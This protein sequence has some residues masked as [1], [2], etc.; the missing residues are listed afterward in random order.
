MPVQP[1]LQSVSAALRLAVPQGPCVEIGER[2]ARPLA[3]V[4]AECQT[5]GSPSGKNVLIGEVFLRRSPHHLRRRKVSALPCKAA[6][7]HPPQDARPLAPQRFSQSRIGLRR[8][9]LGRTVLPQHPAGPAFRY[10]KRRRDVPDAGAAA[11]GAQSFPEAASFRISLSSV[12]SATAFRSRAFSRSSSFS[13]RAWSLF[14]P[15]YSRRQR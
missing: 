3:Q 1:S 5:L 6:P 8:L 12:S 2:R 7:D 11:G 14:R 4:R 9:A 10:A 13:R 15:P